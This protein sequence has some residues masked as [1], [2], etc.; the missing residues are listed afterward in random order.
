MADELDPKVSAAYRSLGA[1]EP[2]RALD[3][4][5]LAAARRPAR[6]WTQ[7]WA[8]PLGLAAVLVLSVTVT[9]RIQHEAP[10]IVATAPVPAA[11]APL[12]EETAPMK[13][14]PENNLKPPAKPVVRERS[15]RDEPKPFSDMRGEMRREQAPAA[16][17]SVAS[18]ADRME[19]G[20]G[21]ESSVTGALAR[22]AEER[23]SRD[24]EAAARAPQVGPLRALAKTA[25]APPPVAAKPAPLQE[26]QAELTPE[27]ELERIAE[28][29]R[30]EKH[31]EAD[32]ALAEF[33]KRF[34]DYK[35]T[36]AMRERVERPFAR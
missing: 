17:D 32:K 8:V 15:R 18:R 6:S 26:R 31:N 27:Q 2:P 24:A 9:L 33:R 13:L 21:M 5:I 4:A 28:L 34:P 10:E 30:Q 11:P 16:A 1:E 3:E 14:K 35:I 20:R 12:R 23:T 19:A 36:D 25:E 22:Q 7:R 29:R